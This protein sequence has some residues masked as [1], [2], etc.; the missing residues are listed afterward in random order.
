MSQNL[1]QKC[2]KK[3]SYKIKN[4]I[5]YKIFCEEPTQKRKKLGKLFV[6]AL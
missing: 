5:S 4:E 3:M 2:Q 1:H 6:L